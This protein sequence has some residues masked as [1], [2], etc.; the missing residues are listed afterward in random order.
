M[1]IVK[2]LSY[3]IAIITP[4][5]TFIKVIAKYLKNKPNSKLKIFGK[6]TVINIIS[7]FTVYCIPFICYFS[8]LN[9]HINCR[10]IINILILIV[11]ILA[12][13]LCPLLLVKDQYKTKNSFLI[14]E[15]YKL[16]NH[17]QKSFYQYSKNMSQIIA[18][19]FIN[20]RLDNTV[21]LDK[22]NNTRKN[23]HQLSKVT[24]I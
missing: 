6:S 19:D 10:L 4:I 21:N 24:H 12:M 23:K 8:I 18:N 20:N 9:L 16:F 7:F 17:D 3:I 11:A 22:I 14:V 5:I 1:Y 13:I 15:D 2:M